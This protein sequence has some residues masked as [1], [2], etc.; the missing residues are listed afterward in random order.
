MLFAG[1]HYRQDNPP[2]GILFGL[3]SSTM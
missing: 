3:R 2:D 1:Y